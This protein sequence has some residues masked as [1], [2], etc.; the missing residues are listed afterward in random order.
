MESTVLSAS[1]T[2]KA[3]SKETSFAT[4]S[5]KQFKKTK[6]EKKIRKQAQDKSI[7][8]VFHFSF[9]Y[10]TNPEKGTRGK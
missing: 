6:K 9:T 1:K 7:N 10:G 8:A 2:W 4:I 3:L 5:I